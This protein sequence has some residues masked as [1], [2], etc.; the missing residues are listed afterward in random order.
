MIHNI[1]NRNSNIAVNPNPL[2]GISEA[3]EADCNP[4]LPAEVTHDPISHLSGGPS[5]KEDLTLYQ[6]TFPACNFRPETSSLIAFAHLLAASQRKSGPNLSRF[7]QYR[8]TLI[9]C[10]LAG[11]CH[12]DWSSLLG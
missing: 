12:L 6:I 3:S 8:L 2:S 9:V 7:V 1:S 4:S 11:G 5:L 10:L